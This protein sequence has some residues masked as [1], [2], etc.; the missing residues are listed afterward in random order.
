MVV[1][2]VIVRAI[3]DT[4]IHVHGGCMVIMILIV[5]IAIATTTAAAVISYS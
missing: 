5:A 4:F 3:V 2:M 1:V